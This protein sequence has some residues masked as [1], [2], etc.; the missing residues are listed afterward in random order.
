MLDPDPQSRPAARD[1]AVE[2]QKQVSAATIIIDAS[3]HRRR[4]RRKPAD[5][6]L[7]FIDQMPGAEKVQLQVPQEEAMQ[8]A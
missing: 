7:P 5:R 4:I 2:L 6:E 8:P 1:V 3:K